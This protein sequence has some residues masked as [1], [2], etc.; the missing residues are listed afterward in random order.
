MKSRRRKKAYRGC[1]EKEDT[2][3]R[4]HVER[5]YRFQVC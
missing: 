3:E 5:E 1:R 4:I 2:D